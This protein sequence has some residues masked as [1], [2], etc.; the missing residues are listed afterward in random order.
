MGIFL[1][2]SAGV[3]IGWLTNVIAIE[4]LFNPKKPVYIYGRR[5]PFTPGLIPSNRNDMINTASKQTMNVVMDSMQHI[6]E[7]ENSDQYKLFNMLIDSNWMTKLFISPP[8]RKVLFKN[9]TTSFHGNEEIK[10]LI[11]KI[12]RQQMNKYDISSLEYTTKKIAN[13]S[14]KGI[15]LIG[16]IAGGFIGLVTFYLGAL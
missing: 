10:D 9:L 11:L 13:N 7:H 5:I 6:D 14:L 2:I 15:K 4:M 8:K 12:V 16:A 1:H 3:F